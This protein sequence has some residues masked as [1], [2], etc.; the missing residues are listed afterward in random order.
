M[1]LPL[2][3][4]YRGLEKSDFLEKAVTDRY[5]KFERLDWGIT[6]C[7][8][9][10]DSPHHH[11]HKGRLY[12]VHIEVR[13]PGNQLAVSH[14]TTRNGSQEDIYLLIKNAFTAME[15]QLIKWSDKRH[16]DVKAHSRPLKPEIE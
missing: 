5:T 8:V 9:I 3:L 12:E 7:H 16:L 6:H 4:T 11:Q 10:L 14:K 13:V 15:R 1:T 2:E